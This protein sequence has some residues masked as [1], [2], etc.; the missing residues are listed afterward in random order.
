VFAVVVE[1]SGAMPNAALML[2]ASRAVYADDLM[3]AS[4]YANREYLAASAAWLAGRGENESVSIPPKTLAPPSIHAGFGIT[5]LV[6]SV[7]TIILPLASLAAGAV[8][9]VRRR[10]R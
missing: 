7:F 1:K 8:I 10:R 9:I 4:A 6:F 2:F 3:A 5:L